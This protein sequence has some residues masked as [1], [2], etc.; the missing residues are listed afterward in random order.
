MSSVDLKHLKDVKQKYQKKFAPED[1]IFS[2][3]QRGDRI[4]ISTACG[5]PQYALQALMK[6]VE[7][8]PKAFAEAEVMHIWTLGVAPYD[9][10]NTP[11]TSDTTPFLSGT[12]PGTRLI[13]ALPITRPFFFPKFP[14]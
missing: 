12:T 13:M 10:K 11:I 7:N 2:H 8:N 5:E 6:Y 4:F 14:T 1:E 3:I 9:D